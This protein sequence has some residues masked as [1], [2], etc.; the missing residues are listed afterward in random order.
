MKV[1]KKELLLEQFLRNRKFLTWETKDGKVIPITELSDEH[2][3]NI[4]NLI[5]KKE[6]E[7]EIFHDMLYAFP[8]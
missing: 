5:N 3:N 4:I 6:E 7:D 1:N 2:L 8:Y